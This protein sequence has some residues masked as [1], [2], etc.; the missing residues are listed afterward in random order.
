M[1]TIKILTLMFSS[2]VMADLSLAKGKPEQTPVL[3]PE[4]YNIV[5]FAGTVVPGFSGDGSPAVGAQLNVPGVIGFDDFGNGYITDSANQRIRQVDAEGIITTV[6]GT[7]IP[8][9]SGDGGPATA[10]Q[11]RLPRGPAFDS[12]GNLYLADVLNNRVRKIT[13]S[14]DPPLGDG[15]IDGDLDEIITTAV[16]TG[17]ACNIIT[18]PS[19]GDGGDPTAAQLNGP[20]FPLFDSAGNLYI[21]EVSGQRVRVINFGTT[22][23]TFLGKTVQAGKIAT[24]VGNG[25]GCSSATAPCGDGGDATLAN[26]NAPNGIDLDAAGNLYIADVI[27][28]RVRK[29][30][31]AGII[32][33]IAGTGV[34]G[35][36]GDGG[37]AIAAKLAAPRTLAL[38]SSGNLWIGDF[39]NQRIRFVNLGTTAKSISG[40]IVQPGNITTIAG[41][42]VVGILGDGG[43]AIDAQFR[44]PN[45]V[46]FDAAGNPYIA[47][48][49]I[50]AASSGSRVRRLNLATSVEVDPGTLNFKSKGKWVTV[51]IHF[52]ENWNAAEVDF[53]S[54]MLQ[55]VDPEFGLLRVLD[56]EVL[57]TAPDPGSPRALDDTNN[58]GMS[59]TVVLKYD[60]ATV[61]SW[62]TGD[63]GLS[64]RVEGQF[65]G[66]LYF[67]GDTE[68]GILY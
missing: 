25:I 31:T 1:K 30:D 48:G 37:P 67:S 11:L 24:V 29:V 35:F 32:T 15:N 41:T 38:D 43:P 23:T 45:S 62:A 4:T 50:A 57:Q 40:Q 47:E 3:P 54:V 21:S 6:V 63:P 49:L 19:C 7:G 61:A 28:Q 10:A 8:G 22:E 27:N 18:D 33:T 36:S 42:G 14:P 68:I 66:G 53:D 64:I 58:D 16:G 12:A 60:R 5:T 20:A 34:P 39:A 26:L 44:G 46:S 55:A 9:F 51:S 56:S 59:D 17:V 65:Q 52:P 13:I 2:L